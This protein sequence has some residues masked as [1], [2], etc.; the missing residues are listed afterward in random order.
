MWRRVSNVTMMLTTEATVE[1]TARKDACANESVARQV[2]D[3]ALRRSMPDEENTRRQA[4]A[5]LTEQQRLAFA[6][7][8]LTRRH[9]DVALGRRIAAESSARSSA[10]GN[11][12]RRIANVTVLLATEDA[13]RWPV[14]APLPSYGQGR[15]HPGPRRT[16]FLHGVR[17]RDLVLTGGGTIDGQGAGA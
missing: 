9:A 6:N 11:L 10:D 3:T 7:A 8:T 1:R 4:V 2:A 12:G 13:T 15:D 5:N 14:I 17:L 16:S